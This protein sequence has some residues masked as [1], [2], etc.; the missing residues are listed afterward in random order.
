M[1]LGIIG[2]SFKESS[3]ETRE[4][5][6]YSKKTLADILETTACTEYVLLSTCNRIELYI[7]AP[8]ADI[9]PI[10]A[11]INTHWHNHA[12]TRLTQS[13]CVQHL[14]AVASG[15]D[16]MVIGE[17]EI[18][19]QVKQAYETA[20]AQ[21]TTGPYLN[22]LFQASI[23]IGKKVR[24]QTGIATG[25]YSVSSIAVNQ[26]R[27]DNLEFFGQNILI[28][29][30]GIMARRALKKL[31][32][33]GHTKV[34][35]TNRTAKTGQALAAEGGVQFVPFESALATLASYQAIILATAAQRPIVTPDILPKDHKLTLVD[36]G[37]PRNVDPQSAKY[38]A[39]TLIIVDDLLD[40]ANHNV[41]VRYQAY[42]MAK[43]LLY[44]QEQA[45]WDWVSYRQTL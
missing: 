17:S 27:Q 43:A 40:I 19:G 20:V 8:V 44:K 22:K 18:L 45:Y 5:L 31:V 1:Q 13:D 16:S 30:A 38:D 32:A 25:V 37:M 4:Q 33:I 12:L 3:I 10:L 42:D 39:I 34:Y 23:A 28:I 9:R 41:A 21:Q 11:Y 7:V 14:F 26:L 29:G 24:D 2:T 15:L 36:L 6:R 35:I